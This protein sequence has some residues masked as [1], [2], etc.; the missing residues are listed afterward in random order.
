M[1]D[2]IRGKVD[3]LLAEYGVKFSVKYVGETVKKD[4]GGDGKGQT[5]DHFRFKL[6]DYESDFYMGLG[7]RAPAQKPFDGGPSPRP[8]TIMY[9]ELQ[10]TRKP[11]SPRAADVLYC[12]LSDAE[13]L[14]CS[15]LDWCDTFGSDPDSI[16]A[17]NTYLE[18]AKTGKE[19]RRIFKRD[20]IAALHAAL[21]D[22]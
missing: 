3:G 19:L 2:E 17:M 10:A 18:C 7:N 6:G 8:G 21:Q 12:I 11:I 9:E 1:S 4:W 22:F 15:F 5:V 14:D 20:Q 16:M 13:A